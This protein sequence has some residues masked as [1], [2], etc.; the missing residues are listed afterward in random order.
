MKLTA[1]EKTPQGGL[2]RVAVE[3]ELLKDFAGR[4]NAKVGNK[5]AESF[6][7]QEMASSETVVRE[8][9]SEVC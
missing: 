1:V 5:T 9:S 2:T 6:K 8:R 7:K 3:K 4:E